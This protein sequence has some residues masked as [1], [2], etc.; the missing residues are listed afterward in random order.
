MTYRSRSRRSQFEEFRRNPA[1]SNRRFGTSFEPRPPLPAMPPLTI[2]PVKQRQITDDIELLLQALPPRVAEPL[3]Q[4]ED[5]ENL[6]EVVL[7]LGRPPEARFPGR[8][9]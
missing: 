5:R 8:E 3:R 1:L 2:T 6:L 4:L 9:V 7:D